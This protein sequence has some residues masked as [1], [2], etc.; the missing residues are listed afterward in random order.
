MMKL[1]WVELNKYTFPIENN[2]L[3]A[4]IGAYH[5]EQI[6]EHDER[7]DVTKRHSNLD[8]TT[9]IYAI[10]DTGGEYLVHTPE[11]TQRL[12]IQEGG[13]VVSIQIQSRKSP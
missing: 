10:V 9:D 5:M 6:G 13:E 12:R 8:G 1:D 3:S 2:V 4:N 11:K 7:Y